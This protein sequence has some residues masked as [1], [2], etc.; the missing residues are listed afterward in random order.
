MIARRFRFPRFFARTL[1]LLAALPISAQ[2]ATPVASPAEPRRDPVLLE[3]FTVTGSNIRRLDEEKTLPVTVMNMEDLDLRGAPTPAE[4]FENLA[5][6]GPLEL[7]EGNTLGADARGDNTAINL[8]GIGSGNTLV[9]LNG[10]RM[11]PHPI[12]MAEGSVPSLSTNIN[13][14]PS[15]A[16]SRVEIL[17]D[18]ASAVY[19]TD[20]AAGV[21][22]NITRSRFDGRSLRMRGSVS[23]HGGGTLR[24]TRISWSRENLRCPSQRKSR[25]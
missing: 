3:A 10:R 16:L 11:P 22:N 13:N 19:G 8:R 6:G 14:L 17:R 5:I 9:L 2:V 18:G 25:W 20:A 23:R 15:A 24:V 12:S 21:V 1:P 7:D 4:L